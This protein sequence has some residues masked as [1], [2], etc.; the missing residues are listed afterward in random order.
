VQRIDLALP[1]IDH[2][3]AR[4]LVLNGK[5]IVQR[6]FFYSHFNE[7]TPIAKRRPRQASRGRERGPSHLAVGTGQPFMIAINESFAHR[8]HTPVD[9]ADHSGVS[10]SSD[11]TLQTYLGQMGTFDL[12]SRNRELVLA[13][14]IE[15]NRRL[16][17]LSM[18]EC[19]HVIREAVDLLQ[20]VHRRELAFDRT[21][22]VAVSDDL[23]K[24]KILS[25]M[26]HNLN[27]VRALLELNRQDFSIVSDGKRSIRAKGQAWSRMRSRRRR[28]ARLVEELGLRIGFIE[29]QLESV[30]KLDRRLRYLTSELQADRSSSARP[31]SSQ[32]AM[33]REFK[34]IIDT[35]QH[36]PASFAKLVA[37][38]SRS[39]RRYTHAKQQLSEGNL[40]LVVSLAKKY[41]NRGS[42]LVDLIQEGNA[43][44]I[45]AVEKFEY[46][47]GFKFS[48]Y[49]T[50]WIRQA[51]TRALSEKS[52]MIRVPTHMTSEITRIRGIYASLFHELRRR[53][54]AE[55]VGRAAGTSAQEA[56][57]VLRLHRPTASLDQPSSS[58]GETDM[59]DL[60]GGKVET[61]PIECMSLR[62]LGNRLAGLL[63]TKLSWRER[64]IIRL[65][66][67]L[68]DG[69]S[70]TLAEVSHIFHVTRER[71]RQI[72][73]RAIEK[74][75]SQSC[76]QQ[77][78]EFVD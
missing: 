47:R 72:E 57:T 54:S 41:Q 10:S 68:G 73:R 15:L 4:R 23:E 77:L 19:D 42:S 58:D 45:R 35:V 39:H 59:A 78:Q 66:Y 34:E 3:A 43:G 32:A 69:H 33:R 29:N 56:Q 25:R 62:M 30:L 18:L 13:R 48:T 38:I 55:E 74:L 61:D 17:R 49:A 51:I 11:D 40:R 5:E 26:P 53:P 65:R 64:E 12:L 16:F 24:P 52:H 31:K 27:T 21:I 50:W 60:I 9:I 6:D 8:P 36:T 7:Q 76:S 28:A 71:I 14:R 44:L 63:N 2:F 46:R 37:R 67:G 70:Y 22:Q 1:P 75:R 20:Q